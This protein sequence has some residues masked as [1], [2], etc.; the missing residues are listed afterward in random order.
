MAS[1]DAT[2]F[3]TLVAGLM[4]ADNEA[5]KASEETYNN[6]V[7]QDPA[8]VC[9]LCAG[10]MLETQD[11]GIF[12]LA[13]VLLRQLIKGQNWGAVPNETK[14]K[15]QQLLMSLL[16]TQSEGNACRSL[17]HAL[18]AFPREEMEQLHQTIVRQTLSK[19]E[20]CDASKRPMFLFLLSKLAEFAFPLVESELA[21][22]TTVLA[23]FLSQD[24]DLEAKLSAADA[25]CSVMLSTPKPTELQSFLES[26]IPLTVQGIMQGFAPI[27][28]D[29]SRD[30]AVHTLGSLQELTTKCMWALDKSL[31]PTCMSLLQLAEGSGLDVDARCLALNVFS[32]IFQKRGKN[33]SKDSDFMQGVIKLLMKLQCQDEEFA[34]DWKDDFSPFQGDMLLAATPGLRG[35]AIEALRT[36]CKHS[37][38]QVLLKN[39]IFA[40]ISPAL[41]PSVAWQERHAALTVVGASAE[42]LWKALRPIAHELMSGVASQFADPDQRV[43]YIALAA[44][45]ELMI[46]PGFVGM[47][48]AEEY[49]EVCEK[50]LTSIT[51]VLVSPSSSDV[52]RCCACITFSA[53]LDPEQGNYIELPEDVERDILRALV[54]LV[55]Q[56]SITVKQEAIPA[57]GAVAVIAGSKFGQYYDELVPGLKQFI[58]NPEAASSADNSSANPDTSKAEFLRTAAMSCMMYIGEAVGK[59]R[60]AKDAHEILEL[61]FQAEIPKLVQMDF[62]FA[63]CARTCGVLGKDFVPYLDKVLEVIYCAINTKENREIK[64]VMDD[65][66]KA[67]HGAPS[68]EQSD[69]GNVTLEYAVRG[70]GTVSITG[71]ILTFIA[72]REAFSA[73]GRI[74][75]TL[76][77]DFA[78]YL[79]KACDI[80]LPHISESVGSGAGV[81][82]AQAA[83]SLLIAL[84][85]SLFRSGQSMEP[86]LK[87]LVTMNV[88]MLS[89][90]QSSSQPTEDAKLEESHAT[91]RNG[92]AEAFK[93][94]TQICWFSGGLE[95]N[96]DGSWN[97]PLLVPPLQL[98]PEMI[99]VLREVFQLSIQRRVKAADALA[100]A[101]Y[102]ESEIRDEL[103]ELDFEEEEFSVEVIDSIGYLIKI[104]GAGMFSVYDEQL[105]P[106]A[107]TLLTEGS[108]SGA[109]HNAL[110][111][112]VDGM[113][114]LGPQAAKYVDG[115]VPCLI[116]DLNDENPLLQQVCCYGLA[117]LAEHFPEKFAAIATPAVDALL[118]L[119]QSCREDYEPGDEDHVLENTVSALGRIA[120]KSPAGVQSAQVLST[121]LENLPLQFDEEEAQFSHRLFCKLVS[122]KSPL[123]GAKDNTAQILRILSTLKIAQDK[124]T[125]LSSKQSFT[126]GMSPEEAFEPMDKSTKASLPAVAKSFFQSLPEDRQRAAVGELP[127]SL[128]KALEQLISE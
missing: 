75:D 31:A 4:N 25:T 121:W 100:S 63:F 114:Y 89:M 53:L 56:G 15:I 18:V 46:T 29:E 47:L 38:D 43:A 104:H 48:D 65:S 2:Q 23:R 28:S 45:H 85:E 81:S 67:R 3:M 105:A 70:V 95:Q 117:Q 110:C 9:E 69:D 44:L 111:I 26:A 55:S 37:A 124:S 90:L 30:L 33:I 74:A 7:A 13:V 17:V 77:A 96:D 52:V 82:A 91:I 22:V 113:M 1:F 73:L 78:P 20:T 41:Q 32:E 118:G 64:E 42:P 50:V 122:E 109:R 128:Q 11:P 34:E 21:Q 115:L 39:Q 35:S 126:D 58:A 6:L 108:S 51:S 86:A 116:R 61:L 112:L 127:N 16:D 92:Y 103:Q 93:R 125:L 101:G 76:R 14:T 8:K 102:A 12:N 88:S 107:S 27:A 71:N 36:I 98:V 59:E 24:E 49:P 83:S 66:S 123:L 68:V 40:I 72:R 57:L 62:F 119:L 120:S 79:S 97:K 94:C 19:L 5:R 60:F 10:L 54:Q 84:W 80:T 87:F 99:S 106:L